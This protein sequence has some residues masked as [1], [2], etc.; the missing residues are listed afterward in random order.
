MK[1]ENNSNRNFPA[2]KIATTTITITHSINVWS[3]D[4]DD[5]Y[6]DDENRENGGRRSRRQGKEKK[7]S[8]IKKYVYENSKTDKKNR[9]LKIDKVRTLTK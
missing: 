3:K 6:D 2:T 5:H 4:N 8:V 9:Q 7:T 1:Y